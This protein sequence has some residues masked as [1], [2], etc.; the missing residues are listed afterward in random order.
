MEMKT[1]DIGRQIEVV[2]GVEVPKVDGKPM[3][4][5]DLLVRIIPIL[6]GGENALRLWNIGLEIDRAI[7]EERTEVT[8]TVSDWSDLKRAVLHV[9]HPLWG[10]VWARANLEMAFGE[11]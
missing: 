1:L 10:Q 8:L 11:E 2:R 3:T 7:G 5:G 4:I 6:R 9:D